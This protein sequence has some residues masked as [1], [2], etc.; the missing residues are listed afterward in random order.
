[1]LEESAY[2]TY[3]TNYNVMVISINQLYP[4]S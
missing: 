4:F 1:M 3:E 2:V